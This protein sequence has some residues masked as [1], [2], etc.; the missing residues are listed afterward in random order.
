M[1]R[2]LQRRK[3]DAEA[4]IVAE[5]GQTP[6]TPRYSYDLQKITKLRPGRLYPALDRLVKDGQ[7]VDS[8]DESE[9]R[10][11]YRRRMY[12]LVRQP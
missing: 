1:T 12:R 6:G 11:K 2:W 5:L 4:K 10:V 7:V 3:L 9:P 8:W